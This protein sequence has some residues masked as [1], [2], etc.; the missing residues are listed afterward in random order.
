MKEQSEEK[1]IEDYRKRIR[2]NYNESFYNN[3]NKV[4]EFLRMPKWF[5]DDIKVKG[6]ENVQAV[7][8]KQLFYVSNHLCMADF[9]IQA[10]IFWKENLP[11]PRFIAGENL[12]RFPFNILWKKSGAISLDRNGDRLYKR[13]FKEEM[14]N[15]FLNGE[16]IM[17]YAEG[18]RNYEGDGLKDFKT[19]MLGLVLD[20]VEKGKDIYGIPIK[21]RYDKRIE[22]W[23]LDKVKQNKNQRDELFRRRDK[24]KSEG[25]KLR[26][27]ICDLR[28]KSKDRRYFGWDLAA[29][30]VRPF[31]KDKGN[32][33]LEFGKAFS[34]RDFL[35]DIDKQKKFI[36]AD[37]FKDDI[38]S[39][40]RNNLENFN[41][42]L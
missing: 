39:L 38:I 3:A 10:H 13:V 1:I 19:G 4:V 14:E 36:L 27:K 7:Q 11:S 37:R 40:G 16:N 41:N 33:Y 15:Y 20:A 25:K 28:G 23:A 21:M 22:E 12:F 18:G 17:D 42:A 31:V 9:L 34:I 32:A 8:D 29:Y 26:S 30:F 6:I 5:F 24:Y 2:H 35:H